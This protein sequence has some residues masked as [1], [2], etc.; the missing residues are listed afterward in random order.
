M[1][2]LKSVLLLARF[3]HVGERDRIP[4]FLEEKMTPACS[5]DI[6]SPVCG[7]VL[8]LPLPW[9]V[10]WEGVGERITHEAFKP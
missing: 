7:K 3:D 5:D 9:G 4:H 6:Q 8:F 10:I 1:L 2:A